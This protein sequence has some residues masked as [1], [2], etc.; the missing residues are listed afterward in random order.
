[1]SASQ[2]DRRAVL[3]GRVS[4]AA[5]RR[6]AERASQDDNN[7]KSVDQQ[8][9][10]LTAQAR[11]EQATVVG[12][13]RDD[14][15]SASRFAGG[16]V[17][18]GWQLTMQAILTGQATELWV[19]EISR[20]TRDRPVWATLINACI[21]QHILINING[22]VHD[23]LDPDDGFMLD[24]LAALAVR[25]SAVTSKRILR[26]VK[27]RAA[28]GLPHGKIPYGFRRE[29]HP[30]T[31][32]LLRQIPDPITAPIVEE[33]VRRVLAGESMYAI[34]ADLDSRGIPSPE[35]TRSRRVHGDHA[36]VSAWRGDEVR[37]QVLSPAAAGLRVHN[38]AVVAEAAWPAI[39][40]AAD[41]AAL[42]A[43]FNAPGRREWFGP[44]K[45]LLTG[46]AECGVCGS[47]LRRVKNR[48]YPSYACPGPRGRGDSCVTRLQAPVD[49]MVT[50]HIL[51]RLSDP[52]LMEEVARR[53]AG[54]ESAVSESTRELVEL[55]G[56]MAEFEESA[57][58]R[59]GLAAEAV[60]RIID[61]YAAQIEAVEV[62]MTRSSGLPRYVVDVAGPRS[63]VAWS[64]LSLLSQ[65]QV[66]RALVRVVVH[67]SSRPR[68]KRGFDRDTIEIIDR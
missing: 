45:H 30:V 64:A 42:L 44:V 38:G 39:I 13:F 27:A 54:E 6:G 17:R 67:R 52:G 29:Y 48:G 23:P 51:G 35:T 60:L 10:I 68:G 20:A 40:T 43:R 32:V 15:V 22:K 63:D 8:L 46:I 47:P 12:L 56:R 7:S 57:K 66:I 9:D 37:D 2:G 59:T 65:R 31:R 14:G 34:A 55:R 49:A 61:D 4:K 5:V 1:M 24:L 26:D 19:W 25:E 41:R 36:V 21:A 3:Y 53:Q 50:A 62:R 11:R 28:N 33:M 58:T 18:E 16:K